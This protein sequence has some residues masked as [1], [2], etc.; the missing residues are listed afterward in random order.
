MLLAGLI[1]IALYVAIISEKID[2][3][4]AAMLGAFA[5]MATGILPYHVAIESIDFNVIFLLIGMMVCVRVLSRTG[6]FEWLSVSVAKGAKGNPLVILILFLFLTAVLSAFLD[7][8]TTIILLAP[9]TVLIAQ[10]LEISAAPFLILEALASN[11]G[12][13]ATLIGDPP[14]IIIGSSADLS[15]NTFLVHLGPAVMIIF[16]FFVLTIYLLFRNR[17][18][19]PENIK[20]RVVDAVP[21]LAII[22][23]KNMI[24][25][26]IVLGMIFIGFFTHHVIHFKPGIIAIIGSMVMIFVCKADID[27][28]FKHV[29]W[30]VIFFFIGLF[31][32]IGGL[33]HVGVLKLVASFIIKTAGTNLFLLTAIVLVASAVL[34]AFLD[35]IPFVMTMVPMIKN[36]IHQVAMDA[37]IVQ[38]DL[39]QAKIAFP[40]WWALALGACLGGNG[41]LIGASANVIAAKIG[42]KNNCPIG[43]MRFFKYG[44]PLMLQSVIIALIYI[45]VRYFMMT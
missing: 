24:K 38:P 13:T 44:F 39:I 28:T 34:S 15:F 41:S 8:V 27:E 19:I 17:W 37:N 18:R 1:F 5:M 12:G 26:L 30:S 31:M 35:N 22:D 16:F 32:V 25:G 43:F 3:T 40:L 14:N 11:I 2:K 4:I 7:N 10:L 23:R 33:E 42:D 21:N 20:K 29:E 9:V 6:F 36:I 45:W